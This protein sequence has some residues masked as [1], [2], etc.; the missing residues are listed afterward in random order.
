MIWTKWVNILYLKFAAE[1]ELWVQEL[2]WKLIPICTENKL[3]K[4]KSVNIKYHTTNTARKVCL[5]LCYMQVSSLSLLFAFS[6]YNIFG[7]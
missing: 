1:L 5:L 4:E 2:E 3:Y 7:I 6:F